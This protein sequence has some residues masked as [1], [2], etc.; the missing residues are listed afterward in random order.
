[1]TRIVIRPATSPN[2]RRGFLADLY[3]DGVPV[4]QPDP[5]VALVTEGDS[6]VWGNLR[7]DYPDALIV[8]RGLRGDTL[9]VA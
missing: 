1:M 3:R 2:G 6:P 4:T 7:T 5:L 8:L 9:A